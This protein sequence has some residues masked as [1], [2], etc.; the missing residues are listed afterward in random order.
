[1]SRELF[2]TDGIRGMA[3]EYPL[4]PHTV[5]AFGSALGRWEM[6]KSRERGQPDAPAVVI[7][8]DTRESGVWLAET[9]AAGLTAEGVEVRFAGLTSTPGVAYLTRSQPF[10]AGVMISASHN[11][12]QDNGL[13]TFDSSA[14][15]LPDAVEHELEREILALTRDGAQPARKPLV[16]DE[17][18]DSHYIDYL[19]STFHGSLGGLHVVVDCA[20]GAA[21]YLG[22][23]LLER[24]GA[25]VERI[26]CEPNGR[27][28]NLNCGA[29]HLDSLRERVLATGADA[30]IAFDGDA[31]RLIMISK[32]GRTINGDRVM[33][34]AASSLHSRGK[35]A[36]RDGTPTVVSTVMSNLGLEKALG[37]LGIRFLRTKVGDRYVLEEMLRTG[38]V[39][40]GE[41]SGHVIFSEYATTGDGLLT[42][43]RVLEILRDTGMDLDAL[44]SSLVIYPQ[45][46]VNIRFQRKRPLEE[47]PSVVE[48]IRKAEETMGETGRVVVRFSGTEPLARVMVEAR[49]REHVERFTES[50]ASAIRSELG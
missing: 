5:F 37:E 27:N 17:S 4:D 14:Y 11:P 36:A 20:N 24:L 6:T 48:S 47:L 38:A 3:G 39:L 13:K 34:V 2:G 25:R 19:T 35:L 31:D 1:M 23:T 8:M 41:Q 45:K 9:V 50:I 44:T 42:A 32:S 7:G 12:Y 18:L 16:V 30:G 40:G 28:I 21:T 10:V 43:L 15:K 49:A 33:F 26:G 29:L 22:P 46:L